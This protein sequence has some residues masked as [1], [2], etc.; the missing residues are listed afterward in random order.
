MG[1]LEVIAHAKVRPGQLEGVKMLE[2]LLPRGRLGRIRRLLGPAIGRLVIARYRRVPRDDLL[3]EAQAEVA[4]DS[5]AVLPRIRG[6][7]LLICGDRDQ[8]FTREVAEET[9]ALIPSRCL[10]WYAGKGHMRTA[11]SGRVASDVLAFAAR[12]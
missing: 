4:F 5:R 11:A 1:F 10:I 8:F 7:I 6:P 2:Y 9:A 3:T 12:A